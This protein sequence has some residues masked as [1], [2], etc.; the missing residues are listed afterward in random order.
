MITVLLIDDDPLIRM[1]LEWLMADW[2]F[3]V[4]AAGSEEEATTKLTGSVIPALMVVDWRLPGGRT[5]ADAVGRIRSLFRRHIPAIVV[6]GELS[7]R[8]MQAFEDAGCPVLQKPVS[9]ATLQAVVRDVLA[10][11]RDA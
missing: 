1:A 5:G 10:S 7:T 2:G 9:P 4:V 3:H 11:P 8:P 6:T